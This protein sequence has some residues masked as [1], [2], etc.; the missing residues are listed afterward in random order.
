M[1]I[2]VV[3]DEIVVS[4]IFRKLGCTIAESWDVCSG[5][6]YN[7]IIALVLVGQLTLTGVLEFLYLPLIHDSGF[8]WFFVSLT[9]RAME[10]LV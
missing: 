5:C 3:G 7:F 4:A 8:V 10:L 6:T 2:A 9:P 1:C